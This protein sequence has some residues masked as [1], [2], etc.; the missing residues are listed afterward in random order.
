VRLFAFVIVLLLLLLLTFGAPGCY[1]GEGVTEKHGLKMNLDDACF[2]E[3]S[4]SSDHSSALLVTLSF[5]NEGE[6]ALYFDYHDFAYIAGDT[7]I[8]YLASVSPRS[9]PPVYISPSMSSK[10]ARAL[11]PNQTCSCKLEFVVS[12]ESRLTGDERLTLVIY[13]EDATGDSVVVEFKLPRLND[14][15]ECTEDDLTEGT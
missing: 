15:R 3:E 4:T 2:I 1:W 8:F 12:D 14:M 9:C 11:K 5:E 10:S 6:A 13:G 7:D